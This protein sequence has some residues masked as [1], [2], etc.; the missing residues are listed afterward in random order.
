MR[1]QVRRQ[2]DDSYFPNYSGD[3]IVR[4]SGSN[5]T[6]RAVSYL[7]PNQAL[8]MAQGSNPNFTGQFSVVYFVQNLFPSNLNV[9]QV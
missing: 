5:I 8:M 4:N 3:I 7:I 6:K 9:S 1:R 2:A